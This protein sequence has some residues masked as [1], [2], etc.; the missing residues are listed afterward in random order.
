MTRDFPHLVRHHALLLVALL[1]FST[2]AVAKQVYKYQDEDGIWHFSDKPPKTD[3]PVESRPVR[4]EPQ[5]F[6]TLR[7]EKADGETRYIFRN[8]SHGPMAIV[9]EVQQEQNVITD[10]LLPASFLLQAETEKT[11][12]TVKV[13]DPYQDS[14]F[15][16]SYQAV[17]GD[18]DAQPEDVA[19]LPPFPASQRHYLS[20][21]F[22][23]D[24]THTSPDSRYAVDI[25]MPEGTP[26]L[27]ARDGR[28]MEVQ[29]DFFRS[30]LD[31]EKFGTRANVVR[32]LHADGTMALYAH[33][34]LDS[35]EVQPGDVVLAGER[36]ARSGNTGFSSGPHLHF[37]IQRNQDMQV[38]SIPFRFLS[39]Q[40]SFR[41]DAVGWIEGVEAD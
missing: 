27:A 36:I 14:R 12:F 15:Q 8:R 41:P 11:L 21:A 29:D 31:R 17:H 30:G 39:E 6:I 13:N 10:P 5:K 32:I 34:A 22:N 18:P 38:V 19:Y 3:Q 23:G 35:V 25:S 40:G 2:A 37:A 16:F 7:Q 1:L 24:S 9:A 33:L 4:V 26:V 28:V 20:Q